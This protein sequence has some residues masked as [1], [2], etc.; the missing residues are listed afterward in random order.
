MNAI[1]AVRKTAMR[2]RLTNAWAK[3]YPFSKAKEQGCI[4]PNTFKT[5]SFETQMKI[6]ER[7]GFYG[8]IEIIPEGIIEPIYPKPAPIESTEEKI[9]RIVF[10]AIELVGKAG[11]IGPLARLLNKDGLTKEQREK[12]EDAI[13]TAID[14][15]EDKGVRLEEIRKLLRRQ[16]LR[17]SV[18]RFL[19]ADAEYY[20][21]RFHFD[22]EQSIR[23]SLDGIENGKGYGLGEGFFRDTIYLL[24]ENLHLIELEEWA[25]GVIGPIPAIEWMRAELKAAFEEGADGFIG[26]NGISD[27]VKERAR[28]FCAGLRVQ[29]ASE[30]RAIQ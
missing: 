16:G 1:L 11:R 21:K 17:E 26:K 4:A 10:E 24:E 29:H 22:A 30:E 14:V 3:V 20:S 28:A 8:P 5:Q 18:K 25:R 15:C 19:I 6:L 13:I 7:N 23:R 12:I 27:R 9:E 2:D